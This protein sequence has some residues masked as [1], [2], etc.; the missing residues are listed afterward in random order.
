MADCDGGISLQEQLG[1]RPSHNLTPAH[2]TRIC[3]TDCNLRALKEFNYSGR[4][5][6]RERRPAHRQ[7]PNINRMKAI[8][9]LCRID[10]LD[11][12]GLLKIIWQR[13]LDQDAVHVRARVQ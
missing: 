12:S 2:H 4:R 6:R 3:T 9:V 1:H 5:T 13:Q 11:D 7:F 8:H 10:R